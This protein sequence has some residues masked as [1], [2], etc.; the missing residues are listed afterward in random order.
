MLHEPVTTGSLP[1]E[2]WLDLDTTTGSAIVTLGGEHDLAGVPR[3]ESML[4]AAIDTHMPVVV[5]LAAC[6][7]IDS[8]IITTIVHASQQPN[9]DGFA[10]YV[11]PTTAPAL[12]R[13]LEIVCLGEVVPIRDTLPEPAATSA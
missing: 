1:T 12:R 9:L 5:D 6:T 8:T 10:L 3:L 2:P 4:R 13:T 11:P 7:F